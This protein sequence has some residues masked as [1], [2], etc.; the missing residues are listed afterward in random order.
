[1]F[2]GIWMT[3]MLKVTHTVSAQKI[4]MGD[5]PKAKCAQQCNEVFWTRGR[6]IW[7]FMTRSIPHSCPWYPEYFFPSGFRDTI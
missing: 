6:K 2:L 1:M 3:T 7:V 5:L 4:G